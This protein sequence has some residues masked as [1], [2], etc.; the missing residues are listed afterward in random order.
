[1]QESSNKLVQGLF[2][3]LNSQKGK[4]TFISVGSKF[5]SQLGELMDKLNNNVSLFWGLKTRQFM[6]LFYFKGTNFIRCI[7][8]NNKMVDGQ[9]D[10]QLCLTQLECSGMKSVLE[11]M[12]HGYPSRVPFH[13]LYSM[14]KQ[15]LP[16]DLLKLEPRLF[17]EVSI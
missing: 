1:M 17:C 12:A 10:G 7:K 11:L 9:F 3:M 5:K 6:L 15:Y 8:P 2:S 13:E 14:Y 4:L 16:T